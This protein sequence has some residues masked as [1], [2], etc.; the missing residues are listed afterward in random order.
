MDWCSS[1][2][3]SG[4]NNTSFASTLGAESLGSFSLADTARTRS[5]SPLTAPRRT[6]VRSLAHKMPS[7]ALEER[8]NV[9]PPTSIAVGHGTPARLGS[10]RRLLHRRANLITP[11]SSRRARIFGEAGDHHQNMHMHLLIA[12][13]TDGERPAAECESLE[14]QRWR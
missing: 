10:A 5:L 7:E 3:G 4:G 2:S 12:S 14:R 13:M 1:S 8:E 11:S 6:P 9:P